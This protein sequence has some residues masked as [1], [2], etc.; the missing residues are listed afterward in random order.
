MHKYEMNIV[1]DV[2]Q[3]LSAECNPFV[4][5]ELQRSIKTWRRVEFLNEKKRARLK[6]ILVGLVKVL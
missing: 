5:F 2:K 3:D 1:D 6:V 4:V